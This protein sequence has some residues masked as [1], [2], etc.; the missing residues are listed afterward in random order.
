[1]TS[2]QKHLV[3]LDA[4]S[5]KTCALVAEVTASGRLR[6][7]ALGRVESRGW[8]K[9][10]IINLDAVVSSIRRAVEQAE[11]AVGAPVESAV[12][13]LGASQLKGVN[14]L[15][16]INISSRHREIQREDVRK[17]VEVARTIPLPSDCTVLHVLPQEFLLDSQDG[18]RDPVGMIGGRLEVNV[19]IVTA[20]SGA[21]AN[22][23]TAANR[24]GIVVEETVLE[25]LAAAE[26]V[27]NS[28]EREL[29]V[30]LVD[31]GA[32]STD[33]VVFRQ[34][35]LHHCITI[36]IGGDHF[37]NDI[38]VG[39]RT[40]VPDAEKIKRSFGVATHL[41][42]GENTSIEVPSVGDRPSRLM[43]QRALAD[44]LEPRAQEVL[45]LVR[46][47]LRRVGLERQV[48]AGV[49]LTGGGA[50]LAGMCDVAEEVL[51]VPARIGLP[52]KLDG[53]PETL[54]HP[55]YAALVGLLF[56]AQRVRQRQE[57]QRTGLGPRI[58]TFF[59]G[60]G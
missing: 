10:L 16:G 12:M 57:S 17:A 40:P 42:A 28:D 3:A 27:V 46:D 33:V 18:I 1:M 26:A 59:A 25:P 43:P 13:G 60:K 31:I 15:G 47:E 21:V 39:L 51:D 24:A 9:G 35:A 8:R 36:P 53:A 19:H 20:A 29:G 14:S 32:G 52:A 38:A 50:R 58:R 2:K 45:T 44:I 55:A 22:L 37:T 7:L 49:V 41:L 48:G 4:G 30:V 11:H 5:V 23:V 54:E 6:C 56:F 34:G